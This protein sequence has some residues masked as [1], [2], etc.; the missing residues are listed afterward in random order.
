MIVR[1][2]FELET[3]ANAF[4]LKDANDRDS[5]NQAEMK[6]SPLAARFTAIDRS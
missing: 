6:D 2:S 3:P 4:L 1:K 5:Q